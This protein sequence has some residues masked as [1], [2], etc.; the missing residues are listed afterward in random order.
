[1]LGRALGFA[2]I[3]GCVQSRRAELLMRQGRL[4]EA[5]AA[6]SESEALTKT[7]MSS[8]A[9]SCSACAGGSTSP[10]AMSMSGA[11]ARAA[12]GRGVGPRRRTAGPG[13]RMMPRPS[14]ALIAEAAPRF[15]RGS[16]Q[17]ESAMTLGD[18]AQP[19]RSN[20]SSRTAVRRPSLPAANA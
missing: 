9:P 13:T 7:A 3:E 4:A 2:S 15:P 17:S 6:L 16:T 11:V 1:V 18:G 19:E 8:S 20:S 10:K 14:A 12:D 5:R